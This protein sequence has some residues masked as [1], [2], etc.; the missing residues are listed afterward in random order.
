MSVQIKYDNVEPFDGLPLP[1]VERSIEYIENNSNT[2]AVEQ[3]VLSGQIP[4][5]ED[6]CDR[7]SYFI[8]EQTS[9]LNFFSKSYKKFEIIEDSVVIVSRENVRVDSVDFSS[10]NYSS[11]LEYTITL[12]VFRGDFMKHN[13]V[14]DVSNTIKYQENEDKSLSISHQVS[15][16]GVADS[17]SPSSTTALQKAKAFVEAEISRQKIDIPPV[18]LSNEQVSDNEAPMTPTATATAFTETIKPVL[19]S[20]NESINR[21]SGEYTVEKEY[22]ADLYFFEGG[23]LRYSVN[24]D[25]SPDTF[26]IVNLEGTIQY[27]EDLSGSENFDSLVERY[28][29]FDFYGAAKRQ[30]GQSDLKSI[31]LSR[32]VSKDSNKNIISFNF[33]FDN[34]PNFTNENAYEKDLSFNFSNES[35]FITISLEGQ[36][37]AR[38]GVKNRWEV[39]KEGFDDLDVLSEATTA[40]GNYLSSVLG[41]NSDLMEK[42]PINSNILSESVNYNKEA[43]TINFS[44]T[45]DNF[46]QTPD[47][48][49]FKSFDYSVNVDHPV[50]EFI[51]TKEYKGGWVVQDMASCDRGVKAISG[52]ALK[53]SG[54]SC[55]DATNAI[56]QFMISQKGTSVTETARNISFDGI[57][58]FTFSFS[59]ST[60][61]SVS[62]LG[63]SSSGSAP[64]TLNHSSL[65][66]LS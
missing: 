62:M 14:T 6:E 29:S 41:Y 2:G 28:N 32:S 27:E 18:F 49:I 1:F 22:V 38:L 12:S 35:N 23:L 5:P 42:M 66:D 10:S 55:E 63:E 58:S 13:G 34:N 50:S 11:I 26:T 56:I 8:D 60:D 43:G 21:I 48:S 4:P 45:F 30:S 51:S 59:W 47:N 24:V 7:F 33:S 65:I 52:S 46:S 61:D 20:F 37:S 17:S 36:I 3:I 54:V 31:P 25:S 44:Y 19:K 16:K 40:Y 57:S 9:M 53:K 64:L 39:A 15:A